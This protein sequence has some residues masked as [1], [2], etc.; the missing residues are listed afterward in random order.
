MCAS[1]MIVLRSSQILD[2]QIEKRVAIE[3]YLSQ[4]ITPHK[5]APVITFEDEK[6]LLSEMKFSL[7]PSWS[8][9]PKV[10]FAT[11]NARI[12]T[13]AEKPT[14]RGP[15][16]DKHCL[17]LLTDFIEPIYSG[18]FAGNMVSFN[19]DGKEILYAAGLWDEW[20]NK[21]TGEVIRSFTIITSEPPKFV[22]NTGHDRCPVFLNLEDGIAWLKERGKLID[23]THWLEI[24]KT[25]PQLS[26]K[27][28][29]P[30]KA[31]WEKRA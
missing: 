31:G 28:F 1:F 6:L 9:E 27:K 4:L 16:K 26:A 3:N 23:L 25:T 13:I 20:V 8:K 7:L 5:M 24:K 18:E 30:M 12:E 21:E 14:W 10:K 11:H 22:K 17:I 29:R 19:T 2:L 15:L